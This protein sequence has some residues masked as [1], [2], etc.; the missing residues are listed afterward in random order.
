MHLVAWLDEAEQERELLRRGAA[1]GLSLSPL[2]SYYLKAPARPGLVL[3][4]A[5]TVEAEIERAGR[6]LAREWLSLG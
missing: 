2:S 3:G 5:G 1:Q 6:W 4:Y